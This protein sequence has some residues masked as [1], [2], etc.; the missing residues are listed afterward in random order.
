MRVGAAAGLMIALAAPAAAA[1]DPEVAARLKAA[2]AWLGVQLAR[3]GVVG[4]SAAIVKGEETLWAR[5]FGLANAAAKVPATADTRYS[6][7]SISKLFTSILAMQERDAGRL[8]LD[9]PVDGVL[10]WFRIGPVEGQDGPV[11][12]RG[13]MSHV[14]GLPREADLPYWSEIA[15]PDREAIRQRVPSQAMLYRGFDQL[16][17]SNLGMVVLGELAA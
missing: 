15:F 14:A 17:Y 7:C 1:P 6:I 5:G 12:A 11:T 4:A 8:N 2:E 10:P 9:E 3:E 16:Q 13:I